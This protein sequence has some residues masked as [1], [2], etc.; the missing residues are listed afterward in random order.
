MDAKLFA[1][2]VKS[3]APEVTPPAKPELVSV[4]IAVISPAEIMSDIGAFFVVLSVA[5]SMTT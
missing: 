1:S 5:S 3:A 4:T 2:K